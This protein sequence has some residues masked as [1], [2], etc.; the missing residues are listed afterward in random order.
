MKKKI[1]LND[2][3]KKVKRRKIIR[4]ILI[5]LGILITCWGLFGL[6]SVGH[7]AS[8]EKDRSAVTIKK[9]QSVILFYRDN[10]SDCHKIFGQVL[11]AKEAG[12]PVQLINTNN[13]QNREKY[14]SLY[15]VKVVPTFV[16][17]DQYGN[18]EDRYEG[19]NAH[20]IDQILKRAGGYN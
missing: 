20:Q 9:K 16:M 7:V 3:E 13:K 5:I 15:G 17:L 1:S 11:A 12:V 18:E 6:Y 2:I 14:L 4:N 10:C 19:T 8:V